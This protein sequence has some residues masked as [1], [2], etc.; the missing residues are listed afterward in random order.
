MREPLHTEDNRQAA[1][2]AYNI[3]DT[4][5]EQAYDDLTR[6]VA[7]T[8]QTPIALIT[9]LD[10]ERNWFKSRIGLNQ[11]EVPRELSLCDHMLL[12]PG[13]FLVVEDTLTDLRFMANPLVTGEPRIRFYAGAPLLSPDGLTLGAI[14]AIDTQ[15]R[16]VESSQLELLHFLAQQVINQLEARRRASRS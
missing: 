10:R 5:E 4:L 6:L 2:D 11:T 8:F 15:P 1:L 14:C 16:R 12:Q 7:Q 13:E 9:F 3:V